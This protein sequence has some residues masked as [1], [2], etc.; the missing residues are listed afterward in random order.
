MCGEGNKGACPTHG[1]RPKGLTLSLGV[2]QIQASCWDILSQKIWSR[3]I[4]TVLST[5]PP[6]PVNTGQT[7]DILTKDF[8]FI[9]ICEMEDE[10]KYAYSH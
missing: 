3:G 5:P 8:T 2:R 6:S 9:F 1:S 7:W 4:A 10:T